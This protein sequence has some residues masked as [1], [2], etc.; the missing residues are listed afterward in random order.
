MPLATHVDQAKVNDKIPSE[1]EVE[2][3]VRHLHPHRVVGHTHL[4]TEY[5][6]QW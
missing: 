2:S 4:S 6:K 1:A 3:V 5:F